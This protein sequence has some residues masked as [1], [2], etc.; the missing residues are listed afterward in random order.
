MNEQKQNEP[1]VTL[2]WD[3]WVLISFQK[4]NWLKSMYVNISSEIKE[5]K[6]TFNGQ[7]FLLFNVWD[8]TLF[9]SVK[10][11]SYQNSIK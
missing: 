7:I 4:N 10:L 5:L 6:W 8:Q 11:K 1:I 9:I 3:V 2:L